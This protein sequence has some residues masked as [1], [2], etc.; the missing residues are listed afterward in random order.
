L[1]G[2]VDLFIFYVLEILHNEALIY[3]IVVGWMLFLNFDLC[4]WMS[5]R[6][7]LDFILDQAWA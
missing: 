2:K 6:S 4:F 7:Y 5:A 1:Y 3:I